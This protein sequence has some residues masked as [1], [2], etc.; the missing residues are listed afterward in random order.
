MGINATPTKS[1]AKEKPRP[2]TSVSGKNFHAP[3][4]KVFMQF[5]RSDKE[6]RHLSENTAEDV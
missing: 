2:G 6:R 3:D 5:M 4:K 1:T